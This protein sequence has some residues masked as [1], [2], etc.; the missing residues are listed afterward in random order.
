MSDF[1][2]DYGDEEI[3]RKILIEYP[4]HVTREQNENFMGLFIGMPG[5]GK[6]WA[7]VRLAEQLDDTFD[8]ERICVT[9]EEFLNVLQSL[10]VAWDNKEDVAGRV[11]IFDEFQRTAGARKFMSSINQAINDVLHTFRYLNLI[12][13]FTTPHLSFID[14]NSRAV[15][16]FQVTMKEKRSSMGL[17]RGELSFSEIK[18]DPWNPSDKLYHFA[19][20]M[21]STDGAMKVKNIWFE[22]PSKRMQRLVEDKINTFK[23]SVLTDTI[24]RNDKMRE[25]EETKTRTAAQ[26]TRDWANEIYVNSARYYDEHR[27]KWDKGRIMLDYPELTSSRFNDLKPILKAMQAAGIKPRDIEV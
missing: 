10:A 16:H 7:A 12:V 23:H 26:R 22:K 3:G 13:I 19:P 8:V 6:T 5:K 27:D 20:R 11:V 21:F 17:S 4:L 15:M 2:G 1:K 18:N 9:Y 25:K 14:I 24:T